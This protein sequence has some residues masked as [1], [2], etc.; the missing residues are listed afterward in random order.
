MIE[1]LCAVV[2]GSL[3]P[4]RTWF[5]KLIPTVTVS[6]SGGKSPTGKSGSEPASDSSRSNEHGSDQ[7][8]SGGG[9][10]HELPNRSSDTKV[11]ISHVRPR[12][13]LILCNNEWKELDD[14]PESPAY[15]KAVE[16]EI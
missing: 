2:L 3:P 6:W 13:S 7:S 9:D 5:S 10:L 14:S 16:R 11:V 8:L 4:L 15:V 12:R 1:I